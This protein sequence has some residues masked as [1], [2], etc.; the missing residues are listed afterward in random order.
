MWLPAAIEA[1]EA[2]IE[3]DPERFFRP[4]YVGHKGWVGVVL[5]S[6]PDWERVAEL[7]REG[8]RRIAPPKL[9]ALIAEPAAPPTRSHER[10]SRKRA[11]RGTG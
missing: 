1:R 10:A 5:D 7:V 11:Q 2:L 8:Y 4:P 6:K 3:A 9:A